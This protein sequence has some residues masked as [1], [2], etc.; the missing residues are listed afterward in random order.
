MF[1]R[2]PFDFPDLAATM[3]GSVNGS[4]QALTDPEEVEIGSF[5]DAYD[6]LPLD[7]MMAITRSAFWSLSRD[8]RLLTPKLQQQNKKTLERNDE[9]NV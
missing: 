2:P 8:E 5:L 6:V 7:F 3:P 4:K 9:P 1:F